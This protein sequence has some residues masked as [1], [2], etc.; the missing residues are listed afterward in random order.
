MSY[1]EIA[2]R[3]A[4]DSGD[5]YTRL[6]IAGA[7][8]IEDRYGLPP[9]HRYSGING[10]VSVIEGVR[11][12]IVV[13][14]T[15]LRYKPTY[16]AFYN[17]FLEGQASR[18]FTG[19]TSEL[20]DVKHVV[21]A[22]YKHVF[23]EI[24][25]DRKYADSLSRTKPFD[26]AEA[27]TNGKGVCRHQ[28]ALAGYL[29][30]RLQKEFPGQLRGD[31]HFHRS[32]NE[33]RDEG[34][35][36]AGLVLPNRELYIIDPAQ[37]FHGTL[38]RA[39][40]H[41]PL[42]HRLFYSQIYR[43][44]GFEVVNRDSKLDIGLYALDAVL[45]HTSE[46]LGTSRG[47]LIAGVVGLSATALV[48]GAN[49]GDDK[50]EPFTAAPKTDQSDLIATY[51]SNGGAKQLDLELNGVPV[52][53]DN[54]LEGDP[55]VV[56]TVVDPIYVAGKGLMMLCPEDGERAAAMQVRDMTAEDLC[57]T[58]LVSAAEEAPLLPDR[59]DPND[60]FSGYAAG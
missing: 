42:A 27:I 50:S 11:E 49:I 2:S 10:H 13:D 25:Y 54:T 51:F 52:F 18:L 44:G 58:P 41:R 24:T 21:K 55:V 33:E 36:W 3:P 34:H 57:W 35:A 16:D 32:M 22:A 8:E 23:D 15:N 39:R 14:D 60:S 46:A 5:Q 1:T 26:I 30:E 48:L 29:L 19:G 43:Q 47:K 40:F 31:V 28:G 6:M 7:K 9:M 4:P 56:G 37:R 45:T 53:E 20:R 12:P 38:E 17:R 59:L